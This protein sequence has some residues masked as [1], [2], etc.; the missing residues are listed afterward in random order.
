MVGQVI[1]DY[2]IQAVLGKGGMGVVYKA[3]DILLE[4]VVALKVINPQIMEDERFLKR[5]RAEARALGRLQHPNIVNV[6]AFRNIGNHLFIVMEYVEGETLTQRIKRE[7]ALTWEEAVP[8]AKQTLNALAY[9]HERKVIHRDV[10]PSNI[11][12]SKSGQVKVMDFG[13]AK[14]QS[15]TED[16]MLTRTGVA[17][18]T[19]Y[20]M[21]PEQLEGLANVDHRCD[22]Y[23]LG[24]SLYQALA[25]RTPFEGLS[26][27]FAII[28]MIDQNKFPPLV[29]HNTD[30]P[31]VLADIVMKS[32]QREP[33]DRFA[34]AM[35]MYQALDT[36]QQ[37]RQAPAEDYNDLLRPFSGAFPAD[38]DPPSSPSSNPPSDPS[39]SPAEP[40]A[41]KKRF[42]PGLI[43]ALVTLIAVLGFAGYT[44]WAGQQ[45]EPPA[46]KA[47]V[48]LT[49]DPGDARV[50]IDGHLVG[51]GSIEGYE[52][53]PGEVLVRL[54]KDGF[55][56]LDTTVELAANGTASLDLVM[57]PVAVPDPPPIAL[58]SVAVDTTA[59]PSLTGDT[60]E[61]PPAPMGSVRIR[62]NPTGA[63]I[64]IAGRRRGSTPATVAELPV[65]THRLLVTKTGYQN[66]TQT[67]RVREGRRTEVNAELKPVPPATGTLNFR[68]VPFGDLYVNGELKSSPGSN[69]IH[70]VEVPAG[71]HSVRA[72]YSTLGDWTRQVEVKAGQKVDVFFI[73][74][75]VNVTIGSKP[76]NAEIYVDGKSMGRNTPST[77]KLWTGPH[78][79]SVRKQG[80]EMENGSIRR[81]IEGDLVN[82]NSIIVNLK[83][84]T[85]KN[86]Q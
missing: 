29:E 73:F 9:A 40:P 24:M 17:G 55:V 34:S 63:R 67:I 70:T 65:G 35:E 47:S 58:D 4:K 8:V 23:A 13:L 48:S 56:R 46:E 20:Y 69:Q 42:T 12:L 30:I 60:E 71:T 85:G 14:I 33:E 86:V 45:P 25:G 82:N 22:I 19:L 51:S 5:F 10:K 64:T 32:L 37:Q 78:T 79:I 11:L 43:A 2:E 27:E 26:S 28:R 3:I 53:S 16:S 81:I 38:S 44:W 68:A 52:V 77:V 84:A 66:Y 15:R 18:G 74:K 41:E 61:E 57:E 83:N 50:F 59:T 7:G 76:M 39:L 49:T 1:G 31:P 80:Y 54:I 72:V 62:S 36:F 21:P 75:E 6:F